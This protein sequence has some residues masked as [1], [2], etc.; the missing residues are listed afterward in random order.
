MRILSQAS[1]YST[2]E[3]SPGPADARCFPAGPCTP[4]SHARAHDTYFLP[5][6]LRRHGATAQAWRK[7]RAKVPAW[8]VP[9]GSR[10]TPGGV[11]VMERAQRPP[12]SRGRRSR[13]ARAAPLLEG[14]AEELLHALVRA[15]A[16]DEVPPRRLIGSPGPRSSLSTSPFY[17]P[18][19]YLRPISPR[20]AEKMGFV[21]N[22]CQIRVDGAT[23]QKKEKQKAC[24]IRV[25]WLGGYFFRNCGSIH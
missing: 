22:K 19:R 23:A 4:L 13:R 7:L 17:H 8:H 20:R 25:D 16:R 6:G 18:R 15:R 14:A 3:P 10:L 11:Q 1:K 2:H 9:S 5:T 24:P 21:P 12:S